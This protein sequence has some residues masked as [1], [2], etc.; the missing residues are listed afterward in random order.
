MTYHTSEFI[1]LIVFNLRNTFDIDF[2]KTHDKT[3]KLS[4]L[5]VRL[6]SYF[7]LK[8]YWED[9][10]KFYNRFFILEELRSVTN[11]YHWCRINFSSSF[12][13]VFS[14]RFRFWKLKTRDG[15]PA[16]L[17]LLKVT[18]AVYPHL[19]D[20]TW[21]LNFRYFSRLTQLRISKPS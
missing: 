14:D 7:L 18:H 4:K 12:C 20:F 13:L 1:K 16:L 15:N 5:H 10:K 17:R 8:G 2:V 21:K 6:K 11:S 9:Q 19:N 3:S